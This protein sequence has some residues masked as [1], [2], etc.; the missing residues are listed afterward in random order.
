[1]NVLKF[2]KIKA[3]KYNARYESRT[4][5]VTLTLNDCAWQT[6]TNQK[7]KGLQKLRHLQ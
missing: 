6:Y 1:M 7:H 4:P 5:D 3:A 2:V